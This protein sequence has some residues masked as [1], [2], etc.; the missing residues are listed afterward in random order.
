MTIAVTTPT[1]HVG[2][3]VVR[4]LVQAGVR[5]RVLVR[6]PDKLP[7][8]LRPLV[9]VAR[10]DL[11]DAAFVTEALTGAEAL[12]WASP[13]VFTAPDPL[14]DMVTM[15]A[16]AA[17]AVR[18]AGVGRVLQIS[19][20]G[21]ERRHGAGLIDGLARNEEQLRATGADV[22]TLRCGYFFTNLLGML[23]AM[24]AG[25][26]TTTM[27]LDQPLSWVDPRDVGEVAAARLLAGWSGSAVGAVHGPAD[28]SW[29][30]AASI[31]STATGRTLQAQQITDDDLRSALLGAGLS[32]PAASGVVGM[33]AGTRDDFEPDQKR[34]F[35]STT[36]ST[37]E[38]WA[39][40]TLRPLLQ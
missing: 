22:L 2:S 16:H 27:P 28:L 36:P 39:C 31:L 3:H 1:G 33:T 12:F 32:E 10:G 37:L 9:D 18:A 40:T 26:L 4:L 35:V 17:A 25:V 29:A 21:A 11:L 13:E 38:S 34:D 6:D 8:G 30:E 5:P 20:V 19:S 23:D 14:A 24:K 7:P 15:G